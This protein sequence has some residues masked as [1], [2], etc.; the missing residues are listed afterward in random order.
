MPIILFFSGQSLIVGR[1]PGGS[2]V[3]VTTRSTISI[4]EVSHK[5]AKVLYLPR[6][7]DSRPESFALLQ[8]SSRGWCT[9]IILFFSG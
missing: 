1:N 5:G 8:C 4:T 2:G 3:R 6:R 9:P 7:F